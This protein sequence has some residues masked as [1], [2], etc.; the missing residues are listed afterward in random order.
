MGGPGRFAE[1]RASLIE[2]EQKAVLPCDRPAY[3]LPDVLCLDARR[4]VAALHYPP[5]LLLL[6]LPPSLPCPLQIVAPHRVS[7][8]LVFLPF[9]G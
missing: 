1:S 6:L 9:E 7:K 4:V 3:R 2:G 5:P 8:H